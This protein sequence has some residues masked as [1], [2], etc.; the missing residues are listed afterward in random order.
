[1]LR[2]INV[3]LYL[4][5]L[6]SL[7]FVAEIMPGAYILLAASIIGLF[8]TQIIVTLTEVTIEDRE[9]RVKGMEHEDENMTGCGHSI[10]TFLIQ[11]CIGCC[12]KKEEEENHGC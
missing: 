5:L 11:R 7:F 3:C 1:M 4:F 10:L 9:N 2:L 12:G 8:G 6:A